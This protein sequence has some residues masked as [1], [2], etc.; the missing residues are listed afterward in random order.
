MAKR[1]ERDE[2]WA[3]EKVNATNTY[4]QEDISDGYAD[5]ASITELQDDKTAEGFLRT[6]SSQE[7]EEEAETLLLEQTADDIVVDDLSE[8]QTLQP[9]LAPINTVKLVEWKRRIAPWTYAEDEKLRRLN[10]S[11]A[12]F[13][14]IRA[15]F[16]EWTFD[17][18]LNKWQNTQPK[19]LD[20]NHP[21]IRE[22]VKTGTREIAIERY[23]QGHWQ[24]LY[25]H[26][27]KR[28]YVVVYG[29]LV[30]FPADFQVHPA[31]KKVRVKVQFS[32]EGTT[33]AHCVVNASRCIDQDPAR[34]LEV[35]VSAYSE[36]GRKV[37]CW[38]EAGNDHT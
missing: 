14:E 29:L 31:A 34:R 12:N 21:E 15:R 20:E 2:S 26:Q 1:K 7:V 36:E 19:I 22:S 35:L 13:T 37:T 17:V 33:S 11:G 30:Y 5:M 23:L 32:P 38:G 28:E 4:A 24:R 6:Y 9:S 27:R 18:I 3:K 25:K 8:L 16:E 10:T